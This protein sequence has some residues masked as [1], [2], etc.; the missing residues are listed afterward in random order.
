[1]LIAGSSKRGSTSTKLLQHTARLLEAKGM[2]CTMVDLRELRLPF[3]CPDEEKN[4]PNV[5]TFVQ[6]AGQ[7]DGFVLST[8][9][10]H[11]SVSGVLK[12][13]L[14]Y[15]GGTQFAGKPVLS[16][17]SAGGAV[18]VSSLT[19][20]QAIVRNMHGIN[21]PEWISIGGQQ[22]SFHADGAPA[23]EA[24]SQR[25]ERAVNT[26]VELVKKLRRP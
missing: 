26:F 22:R 3:Y 17:S 16:I 9:E 13:A 24:I 14:D 23:S 20:L 11:G 7:A 19:H 5:V 15:L 1:M 10:Y 12:N 25:S 18:G 21:S 6:R 4:D 2:T 8:P